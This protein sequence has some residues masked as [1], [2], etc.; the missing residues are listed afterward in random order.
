MELLNQIYFVKNDLVITLL[1]D[2]LEY[3]ELLESEKDSIV[4]LTSFN[5]SSIQDI[6]FFDKSYLI[7]DISSSNLSDDELNKLFIDLEEFK[8]NEPDIYRL[9]IISHKQLSISLT[10]LYENSLV[11][12]NNEDFN[13]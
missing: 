1:K 8:L 7:I 12:L 3:L 9:V 10:N 5:S 11:L 2:N 4:S 6:D 13:F